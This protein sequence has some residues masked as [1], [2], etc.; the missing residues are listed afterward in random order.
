MTICLAL[1]CEHGKS[2]VAVADRMVGDVSLSL[3]TEQDTRKIDLLGGSFVAMTAGDALRH[4]NLIRDAIGE[5]SN[6]ND[7]DVRKA[8]AIVERQFIKHR[9]DLAEKSVLNEVGFS[10]QDFLEQ[11]HN[12]LPDFVLSLWASYREVELGIDLLV[13]GI[14]QSGAHLY[15]VAAP[16]L[17]SC[18]DSIG[19]AVIGTGQPLA[20]SFLMEA[21]YSPEISLNRAIWM[22]YVAKKRSERAPGVGSRYTDIMVIEPERRPG[23]LTDETLGYLASVYRQYQRRIATESPSVERAINDMQPAIEQSPE[24]QE[25]GDSNDC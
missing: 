1:V 15:R 18:Y 3:E 17:A 23:F 24:A 11:Q 20:E 9:Q 6:G 19:Y 2:V 5:I 10:Y 21:D 8:A 13:A 25:G 7:L 4:T 16:G 14:D 22:A 12:L